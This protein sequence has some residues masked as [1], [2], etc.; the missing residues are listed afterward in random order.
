MGLTPPARIYGAIAAR[1]MQRRPA[2]WSPLPV[3]CIGNF[4]VGGAGKTPTAIELGRI[5]REMGFNPGFLTRG[6]GGSDRGPT[7]VDPRES[8][9]R[10]VGDEPRLLAEI[11]PTIV[12]RNRPLG[13]GL[14]ADIGAD[15]I[16]MDD[17]FQ[18]A[19]LGKD[20][21]VAVV[22]GG[23]GLGN[24]LPV[25][26]GP[27]RATLRVQLA[28]TDLIV[29]IGDGAE[30]AS[31][32][33]LASRSGKRLARAEIAPLQPNGWSEGKILA[34]A[35]IGHADRFFRALEQCGAHFVGRSDYDDHHFYTEAD[36]RTL[37]QRAES[38]EGIRLVTTEKDYARLAGAEGPLGELRDRSEVFAVQ[39]RFESESEIRRVLLATIE[40]VKAGRS[41]RR[42]SV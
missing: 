11:G 39:L 6:Y 36:A 13:A 24:R 15:L 20:L 32:V 34:Y 35:G 14:L 8:N 9:P 16:I 3:I 29:L 10:S 27:M 40:A 1:R 17:G 4:T 7:H 5:A 19:S 18:N 38:G 37:L 23:T 21:N 25:P 31:T 2:Y 26:A 42:A 12:S 41:K 33:R 30:Q 22:D 28:L